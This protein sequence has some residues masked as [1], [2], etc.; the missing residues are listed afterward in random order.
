MQFT[1][2]EKMY[3]PRWMHYNMT[4]QMLNDVEVYAV[5]RTQDVALIG[6]EYTVEHA[7]KLRDDYME[8][9]DE[10]CYITPTYVDGKQT[11]AERNANRGDRDYGIFNI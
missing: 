10:D 5:K 4:D 3:K 8:A 11:V 1:W 6:V 7:V 2:Q 9:Y